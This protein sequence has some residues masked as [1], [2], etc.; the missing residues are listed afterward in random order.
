MK[1]KR[2][3]AKDMRAALAQVKDTLGSDAVIM[4]NKKVNGGIE[5]VAAVDYDEPKAKAPAPAPTFMDVSD[6][7]VSLG[8]NPPVR[9]ESR[10]AFRASAPSL[11]SSSMSSG[12]SS[13]ASSGPS[14]SA[15][16]APPADSL[17]ALLEKQQSRLN[18]QLSYQQAD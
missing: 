14:A 15:S 4:S 1:I 7:R 3:F 11:A 2:F 17:Q 18:Q 12:V 10:G 13:N 6:D 9:T 5:I 16:S 8:G